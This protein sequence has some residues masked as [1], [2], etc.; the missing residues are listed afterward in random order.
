[1]FLKGGRKILPASRPPAQRGRTLHHPNL[2]WRMRIRM[3]NHQIPIKYYRDHWVKNIWN[4]ICKKLGFSNIIRS[5]CA[6][7]YES[8]GLWVEPPSKTK[9]GEPGDPFFFFGGQWSV[10]GRFPKSYPLS[11]FHQHKIRI[12]EDIKL[13]SLHQNSM[14]SPESATWFFPCRPR[15]SLCPRVSTSTLCTGLASTSWTT[16][17]ET[18]GIFLLERAMPNASM[19]AMIFL[20]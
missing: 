20:A 16:T 10:V 18:Q 3:R 8:C 4:L 15:H 1:M 2:P 14:A 17:L 12:F 6:S 13:M 5:W 7:D 11:F 19:I 9:P